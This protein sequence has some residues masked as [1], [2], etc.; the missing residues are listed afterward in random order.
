MMW[1]D[2]EIAQLRANATLGLTALAKLLG[3]SESSIKNALSKHRISISTR[4]WTEDEVA[5]L[6]AMAHLGSAAAAA[7]IGRPASAVKKKASELGLKLTA[8]QRPKKPKPKPKPKTK[9]PKGSFSLKPRKPT[10][11]DMA[12]AVELYR[13][14]LSPHHAMRAMPLGQRS[15]VVQDALQAM[16]ERGELQPHPKPVR[17]RVER[18]PHACISPGCH[19][20]TKSA[21]GF[22]QLHRR[23]SSS[24]ECPCTPERLQELYDQH[25]S[26][27]MAAKSEGI[28]PEVMGYWMRCAG[29][30]L[31][32]G[33]TM[34][35]AEQRQRA[36]ADRAW[37]AEQRAHE[38]RELRLAD[39][40]RRLLREQLPACEVRKMHELRARQVMRAMGVEG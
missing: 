27:S 12:H 14:G 1:T 9:Q 7:R 25:G 34:S 20:K 28:D 18:K 4:F 13:S 10:T 36:A 19:R 30:R 26:V 37:L 39:A 35:A 22:C 16:I 24:G 33:R 2:A 29:V 8:P 38:A 15:R 40:R 32:V 21:H 6:R 11:F 5:Q 31:V 3:R 23:L 17:V